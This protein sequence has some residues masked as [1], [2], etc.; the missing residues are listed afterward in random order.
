MGRRGK[1]SASKEQSALRAREHATGQTPMASA[2]NRGSQRHPGQTQERARKARHCT[3]ATSRDA[4]DRIHIFSCLAGVAKPREG[5]R[6]TTS[7]P[8]RVS[9]FCPTLF[10]DQLHKPARADF[11]LDEPLSDALDRNQYLLI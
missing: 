1:M 10:S 3:S 4:E 2:T 8:Y 6:M 11:R 5:L 9:F 7:A